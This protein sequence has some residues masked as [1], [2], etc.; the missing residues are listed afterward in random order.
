MV[1]LGKKFEE[2]IKVDFENGGGF[3]YRLRDQRNGYKI[4]SRN[5]S[6]FFGYRYPNFFILEA[7]SIR[8]N[9]FPIAN[10]TQYD[11]MIQAPNMR[12]L[13]K[14]V[15]IWFIDVEKILYVPLKTFTQLK[16]DGK[17]SV[18]VKTIQ[19]EGYDVLEIP[20]K[21]KRVYLD[22]DYSVLDSLPEGW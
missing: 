7:K 16:A 10:F 19:T 4:T 2:K 13:Y 9:T 20:T 12:G 11:E 14:G 3:I 6:D 21:K 22:A 15:L 17:K 1:S 8:G 5:I 18:N